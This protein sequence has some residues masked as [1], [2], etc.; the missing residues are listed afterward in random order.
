M[1]G[2][3]IGA[4]ASDSWAEKPRSEVMEVARRSSRSIS[5]VSLCNANF[6]RVGSV[7]NSVKNSEGASHA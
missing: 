1:D 4:S 2:N 6:S 3:G 5:T 7:R